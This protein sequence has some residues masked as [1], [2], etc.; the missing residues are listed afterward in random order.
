MSATTT[1]SPLYCVNARL[2]LK[3]VAVAAERQA[4]AQREREIVQMVALDRV[5]AAQEKVTQAE[6]DSAR[7]RPPAVP[8]SRPQSPWR[9]M[10]ARLPGD[11]EP[12]TNTGADSSSRASGEDRVLAAARS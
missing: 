4:Q 6:D 1:S 3:R 8:R 7:V 10:L 2:A 9:A 5:R 11:A 12:S